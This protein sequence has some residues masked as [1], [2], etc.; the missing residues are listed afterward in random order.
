MM[1]ESL[2]RKIAIVAVIFSFCTVTAGCAV[3]T[4]SKTAED[5]PLRYYGGPKYPMWPG[6]AEAAK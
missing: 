3:D 2:M 6:P 5:H 1:I 4:G